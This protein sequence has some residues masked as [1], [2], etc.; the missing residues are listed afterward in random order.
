MDVK[1]LEITSSSV[2]F[3]PITAVYPKELLVTSFSRVTFRVFITF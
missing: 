1:S 3:V 2:G